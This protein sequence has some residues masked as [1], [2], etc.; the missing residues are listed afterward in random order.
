LMAPH[1]RRARGSPSRHNRPRPRTFLLAG[2]VMSALALEVFPEQDWPGTVVRRPG[3][4]AGKLGLSSF[5]A[6]VEWT[7]ARR[8]AFF[9]RQSHS[10][11]AAG[12]E[13]RRSCEMFP[14]LGPALA[15]R[16]E[17]P[18]HRADHRVRERQWVF[19]PGDGVRGGSPNLPQ[20]WGSKALRARHRVPSPFAPC[21]RIGAFRLRSADP[22]A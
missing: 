19:F 6:R 20:R 18:E 8:E 3:G 1:E 21:A 9:A 13:P 12:G 11:H 16:P 10:L 5:L 2:R 17:P 15:S 4:P 7:R 22:R 14:L